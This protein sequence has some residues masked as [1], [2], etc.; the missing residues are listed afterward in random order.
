MKSMIKF[1]L[2]LSAFLF[3]SSCSSPQKNCKREAEIEYSSTFGAYL[4]DMPRNKNPGE[5]SSTVDLITEAKS[6]IERGYI[7]HTQNQSTSYL[8]TCYDAWLNPYSCDLPSSKKIETP[9]AI[10]FSEENARLKYLE[11]R[12][13]ELQKENE[14]IRE[15]L[16]AYMKKM[17]PY[18][19]K[20]EEKK[21]LKIKKCEELAR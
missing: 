1:I 8:G 9:V 19:E 17:K 11:K 10:N 2:L 4:H 14:L 6:N 3:V 20:E 12:E 16:E 15:K 7:L 5:L 18:L 13:K 21:A